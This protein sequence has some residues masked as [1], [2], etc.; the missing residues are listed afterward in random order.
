M[1][2]NYY[3]VLPELFFNDCKINFD[4]LHNCCKN[5]LKHCTSIVKWFLNN[6]HICWTAEHQIKQYVR[7]LKKSVYVYVGCHD[8][9]TID[10]YLNMT[11]AQNELTEKLKLNYINGSLALQYKQGFHLQPF[12]PFW[13][14]SCCLKRMFANR[15]SFKANWLENL[16]FLNAF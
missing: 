3:V 4:D 11:G 9:V 12:L 6:L 10:Y 8:P 13:Q 5:I 1:L 2:W 15:C 14:H 16:Q 7:T